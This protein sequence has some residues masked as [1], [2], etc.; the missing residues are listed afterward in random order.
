VIV[1]LNKAFAGYAKRKDLLQSTIEEK[2]GQETYANHAM[3]R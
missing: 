2:V 3:A 1:W